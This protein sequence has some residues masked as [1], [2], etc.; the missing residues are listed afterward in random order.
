MPEEK[1]EVK[2]LPMMPIRDVVLFPY[3]MAPFVVGRRSSVRALEQAIAGDKK[4]FLATQ[5]D[6]AI[7][8]PELDQI[9][10]VGTVVNIVQSLKLPDG[11]I[12]VLVEGIE[13]ATLIS[14]EQGE[15]FFHATVR[16]SN[17]LVDP[18]SEW[19]ALVTR[20]TKLFEQY[21]ELNQNLNYEVMIAAIRIDDPGKMADTVGANLMLTVPEK[22][23]LLEILNPIDRLKRIAGMLET[24]TD[25]PSTAI[26]QEVILPAL[27]ERVYDVLLDAKRF[28][29]FTNMQAEIEHRAGGALTLFGGLV[30][31]RNIELAPGQRI[32]QAWRRKSWPPGLYTIVRFEFA[33]HPKGT[34]LVLDQTGV[35]EDKWQ[36]LKESWPANYWEPLRQYLSQR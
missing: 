4:L 5:H 2:H 22:Q 21:V 35:P 32:V 6:A 31:G 34:H 23:E 24:R 13:R 20:V 1:Q 17:M 36:D 27:P 26:H 18:G 8:E 33:R 11:N 25:L 9:Y 10:K 29:T 7:D 14:A 30:E 12:K 19:G 16:T 3:M 28:S 15:G